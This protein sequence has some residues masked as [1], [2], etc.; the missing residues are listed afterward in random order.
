MRTVNNPFDTIEKLQNSVIQHGPSSSR[1]YLMKLKKEDHPSIIPAL[2]A[3]ARVNRYGK[4][5]AKIPAW[6]E[7]EYLAQGFH[8]EASVPGFY[9]GET[10]ALFMAHFLTRER[11]TVGAEAEN[12]IDGNI[13]IA[14]EK[15]QLADTG[16]GSDN[17]LPFTMRRLTPNEAGSLTNLYG[18][19]FESYP[20]NLPRHWRT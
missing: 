5:F 18:M 11:G 6:A 14:K 19:V 8:R 13:T 2:L 1:I 17:A 4:I 15:S 20:P 12:M 9:E 10:D 16:A 7:N 3:L